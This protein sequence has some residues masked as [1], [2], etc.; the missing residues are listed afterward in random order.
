MFDK[1][2]LNI[3]TCTSFKDRLIGFCFKKEKLGYGLLFS[4][5][6]SIHTCFCF[7]NL[8]VVLT[9]KSDNVL[10]VYKSVKPWRFILPKKNVYNVYE[11]S[12]GSIDI[13]KRTI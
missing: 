1:K 5:C 10:Y 2:N 4:N 3:K 6:N 8:D 13:E 12:S 11:F 7:Q 9:D